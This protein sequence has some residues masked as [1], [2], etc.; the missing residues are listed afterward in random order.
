MT[1]CRRLNKSNLINESNNNYEIVIRKL[2]FM[3]QNENENE[4]LNFKQH[5]DDFDFD[6]DDESLS[7]LLKMLF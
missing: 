6:N 3:S 4:N 5:H 2:I 7:L 1:N